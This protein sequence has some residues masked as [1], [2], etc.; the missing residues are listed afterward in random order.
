[1]T[2]VTVYP[3]ADALRG[4]YVLERELGHGGMARVY[5]TRDVKHDRLVALKVIRAEASVLGVERFQ[6][7]IRITAGLQHP[8][9]L[10]VYDSGE[11]DGQLWYTMPYVEGGSV[12][13]RLRREGQFPLE[14]ALQITRYV[15]AAVG[16]AHEHGIVHRDIKPENILLARGEAVVTDFGIAHV[17]STA[18]PELTQ[19]GLAVGTAA[20]MS[21]EQAAA[22]PRVDGR[23]D[24]YSTGCVLYEMLAGEPPF[25]GATAQ[26]IQAKHLLEPAP[27]LRIVRNV[28]PAVEA[29]VM[30]ALALA[31]ADRFATAAQFAKALQ[32]LATP[33]TPAPTT[34]ATPAARPA[35]PDAPPSA[36][37]TRA[38]RL[39]AARWGAAILALALGLTFGG[40]AMKKSA[41][42]GSRIP[43]LAVLPLANLTG[44]PKQEYFVEGMH[45]ALIA[46]LAQTS[47]LRV[48][49][50]TSTMHYK[51][52]GK[53]V[54]EIAG[55]LAV[56]AVVEGSVSRAGDAIQIKLRLIGVRPER[57]LW[58]Q[59]YERSL[60]DVPALHHEA[61]LAIASELQ[62]TPSP[63]PGRESPTPR[64]V[65]PA[66]Y[67]AWLKGSY[68]ASRR[69][70]AD[71]HACVAYGNEAVAI[72]STYAPAF[73]LLAQC[74]NI[75]TF[76]TASPP[77]EMFAYAKA[78]A[79]KALALD[80]NLAGAHAAVA[81]AL[82]VYD[83]DWPAAERAYRRALQ[84]NPGLEDVQGDYAFFLAWLGR[85]DEAMAHA[86]RAEQLN[87]VSPQASLRVAMVAYLARSY[88]EAIAEAH[89]AIELDRTFMY[90]YDRLHWA[91]EAK[92]MYDEAVA[93][94]ER[95]ADLA[96]PSDLRRRA[97]LAHAYGMAGRRD[98]AQAILDQL[99]MLQ[100]QTYVP[101]FAIAAAYVGLGD[102]AQALQWLERGYDG[103]DGD[104]VMLKAFPIWDP[105]HGNPRYE[106]LLRQM[107]FPE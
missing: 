23:S 102:T 57:H 16:Y 78:A 10:P 64:A 55:E 4:R 101:P 100:R 54:P 35:S 46:E 53:S 99:L 44:D 70:G 33:A 39:R 24:I 98:R 80:G 5:L 37:V 58:T 61:A 11:A 29:A 62:V 40:R 15:L 74:Y 96:G 28:P 81:Y 50:R 73:Q 32:P 48:I 13:D 3:L 71:L 105:L 18:D 47:V 84:L 8:H 20:Y 6:R 17:L 67:E 79:R 82:A 31:P 30:R 77:R 87:P 76:A 38:R 22:D 89:R 25:T 59:A 92:G 68:H 14:D 66:A 7:E 1:M 103:R 69:S 104:M 95:A 19:A 34:I 97:F 42:A 90:A 94:A 36:P 49:S 12:R 93:A 91:Y 26:A 21:P 88:D 41:P 2:D 56:D 75:M 45:E 85:Y 43:S 27:R 60:R 83:W 51:G 72:D 106:A 9:I 63:E 107:R 86:R 65:H 52:S